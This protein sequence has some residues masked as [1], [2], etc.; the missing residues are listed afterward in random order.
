MQPDGVAPAA[1]RL[2]RRDHPARRRRAHRARRSGRSRCATA[3]LAFLDAS[4]VD[5]VDKAQAQASSRARGHWPTALAEPARTLMT[6]VNDRDVDHLGPI[7]LPHVARSEATRRC[8]RR[9]SA[10]P[11]CPVYLLHGTDDNVIPAVESAL[12][13]E[14]SNA[15]W[16]ASTAR[17]AADHPRR[18]RSSAARIRVDLVRF[19]TTCWT[20]AVPGGAPCRLRYAS[21]R[22]SAR[23]A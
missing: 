8:R 12:L 9:R 4:H 5:M 23:R 17:D 21:P 6:Y 22:S 19:W 11:A 7:L 20:I 15:A 16:R 10:P 13:A 1:A 2:R 14:T 18:G 3:I